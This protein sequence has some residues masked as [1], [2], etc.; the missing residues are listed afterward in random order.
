MD[1]VVIEQSVANAQEPGQLCTI[2]PETNQSDQE[3]SMGLQQLRQRVQQLVQY[4]SGQATVDKSALA[5]HGGF[6]GDVITQL[7]LPV[8]DPRFQLQLS[9]Q[10]KVA[11]TAESIRFAMKGD[12]GALKRLFSK[13]LASPV[14]VSTSRELSLLGVGLT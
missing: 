4:S 11:D 3:L 6:T 13:G 7:F 12:T 10:R 1:Y 2:Q 8:A 14:E 5:P 9:V